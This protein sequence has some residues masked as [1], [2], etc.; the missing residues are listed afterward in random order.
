[1][2]I[3]TYTLLRL[4]IYLWTFIC[5][6]GAV[7]AALSIYAR[8]K[9]LRH[10][11]A[12]DRRV[13]SQAKGAGVWDKQPIVLGGRALELKAK[14]DFKIRRQPGETD[15]QLRR[16]YMAAAT[17]PPK[18]RRVKLPHMSFEGKFSLFP[19]KIPKLVIRWYAKGGIVEPLIKKEGHENE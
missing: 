4:S 12:V 15:A 14:Q 10:R 7:E 1:M 19:P 6:V 13:I 8:I 18:R 9:H 2:G 3:S 11:R 16:R 17:K 5:I